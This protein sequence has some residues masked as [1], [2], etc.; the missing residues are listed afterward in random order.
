[1]RF[2]TDAFPHGKCKNSRE[3]IASTPMLSFFIFLQHSHETRHTAHVQGFHV[4]DGMAITSRYV[5]IPG[6]GIA[7]GLTQPKNNPTGIFIIIYSSET[8]KHVQIDLI[9]IN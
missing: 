8:P 2:E 7:Q 3:T 6:T 9:K 5:W 1:M 4:V